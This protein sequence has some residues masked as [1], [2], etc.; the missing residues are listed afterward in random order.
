MSEQKTDPNEP[1]LTT[2]DVAAWRA[3]LLQLEEEAEAKNK[4]I[5]RLK[6]RLAAAEVLI[7]AQEENS[8]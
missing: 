2:A 7:S 6:R 3:E 1:V 8:K 4:R 5:R